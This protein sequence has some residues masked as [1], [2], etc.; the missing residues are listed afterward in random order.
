MKRAISHGWRAIQVTVLAWPMGVL[1]AGAHHAQP[2]D[3]LLS[4]TTVIAQFDD[5]RAL[6]LDGAGQLYIV[7]RGKSSV[8]Q[9]AADGSVL[10]N[11]G[12]PGSEDSQFDE[13]ADI[14]PADGLVWV[15]ADAGNSRLQRFSHTHLH[16]ET[17]PVA[18]VERF[19]P[20]VSGRLD[21]GANDGPEGDGRPIAIG[22]SPSNELFAIDEAQG[23]VLK[24]DASRRLE[25]TIGGYDAGPGA[26]SE[27]T[28][29]AVDA[30]SLFVA[31]QGRA[32]VFIYDLFG[33]FVRTLRAEN[34]QAL[35]LQN[36]DLWI[37][38]PD[39][40]LVYERGERLVRVIGFEVG[41]S[42]VD[43][44]P[45]GEILYLLT[46]TRLLRAKHE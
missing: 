43:A 39:R 36:G 28:A 35:A 37:T 4:Q 11:L 2:M 22:V 34:V 5:A 13:P 19:T 15:V 44:V 20:G 3:T 17:L 46:P 30:S 18:R 23:L 40:I 32:A 45:H 25:R 24:W 12:G 16:M 27:P 38:L 21:P 31:D 29:L 9:L 6:A 1:S 14:D 10:A 26:L 8:V 7:D 33:S 42:V 41:E